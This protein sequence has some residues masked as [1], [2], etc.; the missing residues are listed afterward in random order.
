MNDSY[1]LDSNAIGKFELV[2][3]EIEDRGRPTAASYMFMKMARR[4]LRL[5]AATYGEEH[6][7]DRP[8]SVERLGDIREEF[9]EFF[10][11]S[12]IAAIWGLIMFQY[13]ICVS[14]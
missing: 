8:Q 14:E 4:Q 10:S 7:P 1:H 2:G 13:N 3:G 6:L 12:S 5:F 9:P 11:A